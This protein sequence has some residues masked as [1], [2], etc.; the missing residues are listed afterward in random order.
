MK[1][2]AICVVGSELQTV[3]C[4]IVEATVEDENWIDAFAAIVHDSEQVYQI[5]TNELVSMW[6][7]TGWDQRFMAF[8]QLADAVWE[9]FDHMRHREL[10]HR[11]AGNIVIAGPIDRE[12]GFPTD[13]SEHVVTWIN[14]TVRMLGGYRT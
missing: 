4:Q 10:G 5:P 3:P 11:L 12:S 9:H 1:I 6:G 8:N 7:R 2:L 14:E 13:V